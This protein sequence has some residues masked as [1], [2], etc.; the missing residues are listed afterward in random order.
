MRT[1]CWTY[2]QG[3]WEKAD[4]HLNPRSREQLPWL[5]KAATIGC[6][7]YGDHSADL[8]RSLPALGFYNYSEPA[9]AMS[10]ARKQEVLWHRSLRH[11][12]QA[13]LRSILEV[14]LTYSPEMLSHKATFY[15]CCINKQSLTFFCV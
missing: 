11:G 4:D 1:A 3:S 8:L 10:A 2:A 14:T 15:L 5:P 7:G 6:F 13:F 9:E 12:K